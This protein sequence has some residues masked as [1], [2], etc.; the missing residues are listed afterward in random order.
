MLGAEFDWQ[1]TSRWRLGFGATRVE[2]QRDRPDAAALDWDQWRLS[3]R[4]TLLH[5]TDVD[6]MALPRAIRSEPRP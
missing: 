1:P 6:R 4:V 2:E 3:A 5:G